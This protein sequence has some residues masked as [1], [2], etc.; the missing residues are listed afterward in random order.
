MNEA[1]KPYL[2]TYS[3]IDPVDHL[4]KKIY[5]KDKFWK[6]W[7]SPMLCDMSLVVV[8]TQIMYLKEA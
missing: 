1:H 3:Y 4:I 8:S 2:G 6:Y 5:M 7:H